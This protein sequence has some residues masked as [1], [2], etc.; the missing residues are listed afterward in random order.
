MQYLGQPYVYGFNELAAGCGLIAPKAAGVLGGDVYWMSQSQFFTIV[1]GSP[2]IL[3]CSVWDV[4]FQNLDTANY[5]SIRCA[6]NSR[7]SEIAWYYPTVGS[8][9]VNTNYVKYNQVLNCWDFGVLGR[10]AWVDQSVLG[11]P[12]GTDAVT[13]MVY[14]HE[15]STS[16]PGTTSVPQ[17][18]TGWFALAEGDLKAFVDEVWPDMRWNY[19][20]KSGSAQVNVTFTTAD[21]PFQ[22]TSTTPP[23]VTAGPYTFTNTS[24]YITPRLRG[25]LMSINVASSGMNTA[26]WRLGNIRYR[27]M[28]DGKY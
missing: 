1:N 24:T 17:F 19:Y 15:T 25:R 3:P 11:A 22:T 10:S 13:N 23:A 27:V 18:T 26:F 21:F 16:Y 7:F 6:P 5:A 2:Q 8:N 28:L 4:V 14:Q 9:G 20:G 12:I